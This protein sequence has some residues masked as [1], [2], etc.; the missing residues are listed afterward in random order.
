MLYEKGDKISKRSLKLMTNILI[1]MFADNEV[2]AYKPQLHGV[3]PT[4][5]KLIASGKILWI[6]VAINRLNIELLNWSFTEITSL[7]WRGGES[8][9]TSWSVISKKRGTGK[10]WPF[11]SRERE[12][13]SLETTKITVTRIIVD[14]VFTTKMKTA[15]TM[16]KN[17]FFVVICKKISARR[18]GT[19]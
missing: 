14:F 11:Q 17:F 1:T 2:L 4:L 10:K 15:R 12:R 6:S 9:E 5:K 7:S 19:L 3:I 13:E 16:D 18:W 8:W